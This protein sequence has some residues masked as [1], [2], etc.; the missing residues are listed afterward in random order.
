MTISLTVNEFLKPRALTL[1]DTC[2]SIDTEMY[3]EYDN[4]EHIVTNTLFLHGTP[5]ELLRFF[6]WG[7]E[8]CS[9]ARTE[10]ANYEEDSDKRIVEPMT[11]YDPAPAI[12]RVSEELRSTFS[13]E[14]APLADQAEE[15]VDTDQGW[16]E[17]ANAALD[18]YEGKGVD[19]TE[20]QDETEDETERSR[21]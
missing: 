8:A 12:Q 2:L 17:N 1:D 15:S 19:H 14:P 10:P 7:V 5:A 21:R 6:E 16:I 18:R 3:R 13:T 4:P 11:D 9:V 20:P